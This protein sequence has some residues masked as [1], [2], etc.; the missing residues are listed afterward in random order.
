MRNTLDA[1]ASIRNETMVV[2]AFYSDLAY[3]GANLLTGC[4]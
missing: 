2:G 4:N 3:Y 1:V